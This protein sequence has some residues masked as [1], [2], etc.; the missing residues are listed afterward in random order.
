M[1]F[2]L[3][4]RS[5]HFRADFSKLKKGYFRSLKSFPDRITVNAFLKEYKKKAYANI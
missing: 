1:P 4:F 5:L 2:I 3:N